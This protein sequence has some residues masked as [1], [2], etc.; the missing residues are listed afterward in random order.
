MKVLHQ[1]ENILCFSNISSNMH[2]LLVA[3][4]ESFVD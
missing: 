3:I 4:L 2:M 1:L